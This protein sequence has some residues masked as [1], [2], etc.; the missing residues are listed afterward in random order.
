MVK[1]PLCDLYS[2]LLEKK[3]KAYC[4][5]MEKDA[6]KQHLPAKANGTGLNS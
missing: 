4:P 3:K 6:V 5:V 1:Y 2:V